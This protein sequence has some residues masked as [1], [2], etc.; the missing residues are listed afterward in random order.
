M[1][2][3]HPNG[4]IV[5]KTGYH[6]ALELPYPVGKGQKAGF[7]RFA[8]SLDM[9]RW[10]KEAIGPTA[11]QHEW[12]LEDKGQWIHT[13]C[14]TPSRLTGSHCLAHFW[15]RTPQQAMLFKLAF[16]GQ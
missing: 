6:I 16:A 4:T 13:G 14:T 2:G 12:E 10:L 3:P 15:F 8:I 9:Y 1:S 11:K 7:W 5:V